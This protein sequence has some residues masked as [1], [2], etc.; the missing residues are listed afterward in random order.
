VIADRGT[1]S[2]GTGYDPGPQHLALILIEPGTYN[3]QIVLP[4]FCDLVGATGDPADVTVQSDAASGATLE[5][6]GVTAYVAGIKFRQGGSVNAAVGG[7]YAMHSDAVAAFPGTPGYGP[8]LKVFHNCVFESANPN[9]AEAAGVGMPGR[10]AH[11]FIGCTFKPFGTST[12]FNA[13]N[14]AT[15]KRPATLTFVN[16]TFATAAAASLQVSDLGSTQMDR[17]T[18]IGGHMPAATNQ[19]VWV[20][21]TGTTLQLELD[22]AVVTTPVGNN[23]NPTTVSFVRSSADGIIAASSRDFDDFYYPDRRGRAVELS[24]GFGATLAAAA[25]TANRVYY[26]PVDIDAA[27][28]VQKIRVAAAAAGGKVAA[29]IYQDD[30]TGKPGAYLTRSNTATLVV[31]SNAVPGFYLRCAWPGVRTVWIGV[32]ADTSAAASGL[33][34]TASLSTTR[35]LFYEDIAAGWA[36]TPTTPTPV[37]LAPGAVVPWATLTSQ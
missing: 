21:Q 34:C 14:T 12:A 32:V 17:V 28:L 35:A 1:V 26:L 24:P 3:E 15:Q 30:G 33:L 8:T 25:L 16:C 13:H 22:P 6:G 9:R 31:G 27:Y 36:N 7:V 20:T 2:T 29:G 11:M 19:I 23:V 10:S 4:P 5:L 18:V 37:A